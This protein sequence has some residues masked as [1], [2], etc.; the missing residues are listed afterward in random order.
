MAAEAPGDWNVV[1]VA[2]GDAAGM[3]ILDDRAAVE[4]IVQRLEER[5]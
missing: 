1:Y 5:R 4:V 3:A 2:P